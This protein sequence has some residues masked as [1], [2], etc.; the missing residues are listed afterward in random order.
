MLTIIYSALS[1]I[2]AKWV[3]RSLPA[4]RDPSRAA[5]FDKRLAFYRLLYTPFSKFGTMLPDFA[6]RTYYSL[7]EDFDWNHGS[8]PFTLTPLPRPLERYIRD[9]TYGNPFAGN[10]QIDDSYWKPLTAVTDLTKEV[11]VGA[12]DC[13]YAF[14]LPRSKLII[15]RETEGLFILELLDASDYGC[16]PRFPKNKARR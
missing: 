11:V 3:R 9:T 13:D 2:A 1:P 10:D 15:A 5:V 14:Y 4:T 16:P 12:A 8:P 6:K 7:Y